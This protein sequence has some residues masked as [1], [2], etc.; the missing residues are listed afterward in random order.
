MDESFRW[1]RSIFS[2]P[3]ENQQEVSVWAV[4]DIRF[5]FL[6]GTPPFMR[7]MGSKGP[8]GGHQNSVR[9]NLSTDHV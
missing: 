6:E 8:F 7:F 3:A 4:G 9:M 1:G 5:S 2:F